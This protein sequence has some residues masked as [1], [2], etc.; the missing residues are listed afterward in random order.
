M[1]RH[2][3]CNGS[4]AVAGSNMGCS[5][6]LVQLVF[7]LVLVLVR[8]GLW[9]LSNENFIKDDIDISDVIMSLC[10]DELSRRFPVII[11]MY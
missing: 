11:V 1:H 4:L 9:S 5:R 3:E 6:L 8:Y 7:E 2:F 10:T